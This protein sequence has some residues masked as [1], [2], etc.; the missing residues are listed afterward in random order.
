MIQAG[1][2]FSQDT[3]MASIVHGK[4]STDKVKTRRNNHY[5]C[6]LRIYTGVSNGIF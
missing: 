3:T 1:W 5:W 4:E 2:D 6:D